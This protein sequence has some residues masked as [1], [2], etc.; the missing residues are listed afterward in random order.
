[1]LKKNYLCLYIIF[2]SLVVQV[3]YPSLDGIQNDLARFRL[4]SIDDNNSIKNTSKLNHID[5]YSS[6]EEMHIPKSNQAPIKRPI[7]DRSTKVFNF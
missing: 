5:N 4:K 6:E 2:F 3:K 7:F 1:M